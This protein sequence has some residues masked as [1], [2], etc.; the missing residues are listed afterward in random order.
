MGQS[1][2][3]RL[4]AP[5]ETWTSSEWDSPSFPRRAISKASSITYGGWNDARARDAGP[6]R[7]RKMYGT[8]LESTVAGL[9]FNPVALEG[10]E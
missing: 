1:P 3:R 2:L 10:F 8:P 9:A 5:R 4:E 6:N 7:M